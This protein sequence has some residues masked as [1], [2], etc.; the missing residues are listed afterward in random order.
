MKGLEVAAWTAI[1]GK[2]N[3]PWKL[4]PLKLRKVHCRVLKLFAHTR[5]WETCRFLPQN[6]TNC[7]E[8]CINIK[9]TD[10]SII[11]PFKITRC[12]Y[13][14]RNAYSKASKPLQ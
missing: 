5:S 1:G 6:Y 3:L 11:C 14:Q 2:A 9:S 13:P 8:V 12:L 7:S 10:Y 4:F